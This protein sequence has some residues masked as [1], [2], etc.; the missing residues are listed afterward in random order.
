ML[1]IVLQICWPEII[2]LTNYSA[3]NN[4]KHFKSSLWSHLY[5][6]AN[7]V[8]KAHSLLS[9]KT[10]NLFAVWRRVGPQ[11]DFP[12]L[13]ASLVPG[14]IPFLILLP[15]SVKT[16]VS[17]S[18]VWFCTYFV[19]L[20]PPDGAIEQPRKLLSALQI[21]IK[22]NKYINKPKTMREKRGCNPKQQ[23]EINTSAW[24]RQFAN[25]GNASVR[26]QT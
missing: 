26:A 23:P 14:L 15:D 9:Q 1:I 24:W 20:S 19:P 6:S 3:H 13:E 25:E 2:Q 18:L 5:Y 21:Y 4:A 7:T 17:V 10:S 12:Q 22:I 11:F 8:T 16:R